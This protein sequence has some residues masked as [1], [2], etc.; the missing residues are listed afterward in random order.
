MILTRLSLIGFRNLA[1]QELVFSPHV[2]II[3]GANGQGK[4]NL[5]EAIYVLGL[6]RSFRTHRTR[7]LIRRSGTEFC[8]SGDLETA[9]QGLTLSLRLGED[10]KILVINGSRRD[11]FEYVGHFNAIVFSSIQL[12]QF[13]TDPEHRRRSVDRGLYFLQ[14]AHLRRMA[15]YS[16]LVKQK[17]S[18]LRNSASLYNKSTYE[19]L[20]VWDVQIAELGSRIIK[21][22]ACYIEKVA[23]RLAVQCNAFTPDS[24][25]ISYLA[26]NQVTSTAGLVE[27]QSQLSQRL[28]ENRDQELR[29]RRCMTGPHR[30]EIALTIDG[31]PMQHYA[32]AGQQ[33]SALLAYNLA[34][35]EVYFDACGSYPVFLI[36]DID[37]E[38]DE[39]RMNDLLQFLQTKTQVFLTT[40]KPSLIHL[41]SSDFS[42]SSFRVESGKILE[43]VKPRQIRNLRTGR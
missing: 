39:I 3:A 21:A 12:E 43:S 20:D 13:R 14:P 26:A 9:G 37:S 15:E 23:K 22:R 33:R 7:D 32:S 31:S 35:L 4:T 10:G 27:I 17:N 1:E 36:D 18:L 30:D 24:L 41:T 5:L 42:T 34:Q 19:L 6:S 2:N 40:T 29:T 28:R 16:R 8:L 11:V 25:E 38:L